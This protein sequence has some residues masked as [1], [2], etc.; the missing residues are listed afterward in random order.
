MIPLKEDK[1]RWP[2]IRAEEKLREFG[3]D[4]VTIIDHKSQFHWGWRSCLEWIMEEYEITPKKSS[5]KMENGETET[6]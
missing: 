5:S 4:K 2:A 1:R 3:P 6:K